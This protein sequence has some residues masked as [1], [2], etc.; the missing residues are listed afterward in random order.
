VLLGFEWRKLSVFR[1]RIGGM[2]I[3]VVLLAVLM[4]AGCGTVQTVIRGDEVTK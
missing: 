4:L 1:R 2:K 3:Q